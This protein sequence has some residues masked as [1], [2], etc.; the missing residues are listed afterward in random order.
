MSIGLDP[1]FEW[2]LKWLDKGIQKGWNV[3]GDAASTRLKRNQLEESTGEWKEGFISYGQ[4]WLPGFTFEESTMYFNDLTAQKFIDNLQ[5][6]GTLGPNTACWVPLAAACG[7]RAPNMSDEE[8]VLR[9]MNSRHEAVK[10]ARAKG[11]LATWF[12]GYIPRSLTKKLT[13]AQMAL[14][15]IKYLE[16]EWHCNRLIDGAIVE[17]QLTKSPALTQMN[18]QCTF[19]SLGVLFTINAM[20]NGNVKYY[21]YVEKSRETY[22]IRRYAIMDNTCFLAMAIEADETNEALVCHIHYKSNQPW[23]KDKGRRYSDCLNVIIH[24]ASTHE[25]RF[26]HEEGHV[27]TGLEI[28]DAVKRLD[29]IGWIMDTKT[30][31]AVQEALKRAQYQNIGED[32]RRL[33]RSIESA[34]T[35][36]TH[37]PNITNVLLIDYDTSYFPSRCTSCIMLV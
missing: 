26:L 19:A 28:T 37:K 24:G 6:Y 31:M 33:F 2:A 27:P 32:G 20:L 4:A 16:K 15:R 9:W 30:A 5:N 12:R 14:V 13:R 36:K 25:V 21:D 34:L 8:A 29:D 35:G 1:L 7:M 3:A 17:E 23:V 22:P 11:I 18:M 10:E